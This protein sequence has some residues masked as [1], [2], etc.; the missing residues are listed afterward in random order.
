[1]FFLRKL[2][3]FLLRRAHQRQHPRF[4]TPVTH[5]NRRLFTLFI[6][7]FSGN[8]S[9]YP[10]L[11][12]KINQSI[13]LPSTLRVGPGARLSALSSKLRAALRAGR[14]C[15]SRIRTAKD[16]RQRPPF[17][18][19]CRLWTLTRHVYQETCPRPTRRIRTLRRRQLALGQTITGH[20]THRTPTESLRNTQPPLMAPLAG[21]TLLT[22]RTRTLH[23]Y[24]RVRQ[25][26]TSPRQWHRTPTFDREG[27][28]RISF[29]M[30]RRG[31]CKNVNRIHTLPLLS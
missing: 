9:I 13:S 30:V 15:R 23:A 19:M 17:W 22:F 14:G 11:S 3:F 7:D 2:I 10:R 18:T 8:D 12:P 26:R 16:L 5:F 1:M 29:Q 21:Q 4:T 31:P 27:R 24:P 20:L 6:F 28:W 25:Y